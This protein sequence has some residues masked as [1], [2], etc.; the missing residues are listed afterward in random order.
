MPWIGFHV[1]GTGMANLAHMISGVGTPSNG[2]STC[3]PNFGPQYQGELDCSRTL[4]AG[5][6]G[7]ELEREAPNQTISAPAVS[8][9]AGVSSCPYVPAYRS[10]FVQKYLWICGWH[11]T[12]HALYEFPAQP[13]MASAVYE[14]ENSMNLF[15]FVSV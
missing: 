9:E 10:P 3:S 5:A 14:Y 12:S 4:V 2:W 1:Q 8:R 13:H 11:S 7:L 6:N 15:S